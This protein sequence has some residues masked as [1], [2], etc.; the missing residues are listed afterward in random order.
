MAIPPWK[1]PDARGWIGV[2]VFAISVMLLRMMLIKELRE[3]E[4]FQTIATV[5]IS[6]G[7]MAVVAWAYAATKGGGELAE[8]NAAIVHENASAGVAA[9]TT[10]A[11]V[12]ANALPDS[13]KKP[14]PDKPQKV[15][16]ENTEDHPAIV[17]DTTSP[18]KTTE[19]QSPIPDEADV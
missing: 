18:S 7:L 2:G 15:I 12:T 19:N 13:D 14:D 10:L 4:F 6:N 3:D 8:K 17:S 9:A 16:V 1:W 11:A 5:I